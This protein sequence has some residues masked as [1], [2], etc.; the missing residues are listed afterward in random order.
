L[1][2]ENLRKRLNIDCCASVALRWMLIMIK[3]HVYE[4]PTIKALPAKRKMSPH[5]LRKPAELLRVYL[6]NIPQLFMQGVEWPVSHH[7]L[8]KIFGRD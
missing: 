5:G 7:C 4:A 2:V 8:W 3:K 1:S 6:C